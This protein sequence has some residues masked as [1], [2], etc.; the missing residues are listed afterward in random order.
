MLRNYIADPCG[1][2]TKTKNVIARNVAVPYTDW[3]ARRQNIRNPILA[4]S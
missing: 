3:D 1:P 2:K 4:F